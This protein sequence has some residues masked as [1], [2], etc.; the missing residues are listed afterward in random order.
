MCSGASLAVATRHVF[1]ASALHECYPL[2][3]LA[4]ILQRLAPL[5]RTQFPVLN[6]VFPQELQVQ[7]LLVG[8]EVVVWCHISQI[9][10]SWVQR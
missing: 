5:E 1:E 2:R 10:D 6:T 7:P 4:C 3:R 8:V 9:L